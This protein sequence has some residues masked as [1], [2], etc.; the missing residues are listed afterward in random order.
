MTDID[1]LTLR[2]W[3]HQSDPIDL[4]ITAIRQVVDVQDIIVAA[5]SEAVLYRRR[6]D[7]LDQS[8]S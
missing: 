8:Q 2:S 1:T 5:R 4:A 3:A 7:E 6:A